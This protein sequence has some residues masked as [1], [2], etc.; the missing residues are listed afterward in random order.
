MVCLVNAASMDRIVY[1]IF[2]K[3]NGQCENEPLRILHKHL[4]TLV[5]VAL[6]LAPARD[7]LPRDQTQ[8]GK[9]EVAFACQTIFCRVH[10]RPRPGK[11]W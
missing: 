2:S 1:A 11:P 8:P 4:V 9:K 5:R 7:I 10:T 3:F 6:T